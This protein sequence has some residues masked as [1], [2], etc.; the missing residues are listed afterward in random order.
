LEAEPVI[1]AMSNTSGK[2]L[3]GT[4]VTMLWQTLVEDPRLLAAFRRELDRFASETG[5]KVT[6]VDFPELQTGSKPVR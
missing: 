4:E 2:P 3:A 1:P 6:L 5:I